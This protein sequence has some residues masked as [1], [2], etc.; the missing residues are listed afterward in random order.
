MSSEHG[1]SKF[2]C[3]NFIGEIHICSIAKDMEV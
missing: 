2:I 3:T 1:V